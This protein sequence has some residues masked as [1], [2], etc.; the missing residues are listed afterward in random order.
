MAA[1]VASRAQA[2]GADPELLLEGHGQRVEVAAGGIVGFVG[3]EPARHL[4][5]QRADP[6]AEHADLLLLQHTLIV[7]ASSIACR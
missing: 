1:G 6:L 4:V 3:S 5:Q 7:R 2:H